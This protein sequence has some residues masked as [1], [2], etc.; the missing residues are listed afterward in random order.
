[1]TV[2]ELRP[3]VTLGGSSAAAAA[4]ID[5]YRSR[6]MLWLEVTGRVERPDAE[7][8]RWGTLLE[9]PIMEALADDGYEVTQPLDVMRGVCDPERAW[10]VGHPD[11]FVTLDHDTALLEV[12]TAGPFAHKW[13]ES[14]PLHYQAQCQVYMHLTGLRRALLACL[15]GGQRLVL[16]TIDRDDTAI[17]L[18]L[19]ALEDFYGYVQRDEPPPPDGSDSARDALAA[20]YPKATAGLVHRLTAAEWEQVRELRA[21]REQLAV[22]KA[23]VAEL[24]AALKAAMGDA[25]TALSPFDT[26]ALHWRNVSRTAVDVA[27]FKELR[28]E[29]A[30]L[31]TST[32]ESR[33]FTVV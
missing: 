28:P 19:D 23:Q 26:E 27:R 4:G 24:E 25:E 29:L 13:D 21:R 5:P 6:V 9:R 33:R 8:M 31:F 18:L 2:T 32:T 22:V 15:V 3:R 16:Q 14:A 12:K 1:M 10:L 7:A 11:G 30:S 17:G 20:M